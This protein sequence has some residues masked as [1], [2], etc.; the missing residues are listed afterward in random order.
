MKFDI[1]SSSW[2]RLDGVHDNVLDGS[3]D[4]LDLGQLALTSRAVPSSSRLLEILVACGVQ[5]LATEAT[6]HASLRVD[7]TCT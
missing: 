7:M 4:N 1:R 6:L 2:A 3:I 5:V